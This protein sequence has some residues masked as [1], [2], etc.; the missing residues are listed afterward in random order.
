MN[1]AE[2]QA[3]ENP[4]DLLS[5]LEGRTSARKFR[6]FAAAV[7]R[8]AGEAG[9]ATFV[10]RYA[11]GQGGDQEMATLRALAEQRWRQRRGVGGRHRPQRM[12]Q[13]GRA[14]R[15]AWEALQPG[16][17]DAALGAARESILELREQQCE[18]LREVIGNPLA[19]VV[20]RTEWLAWEGGIVRR[21]ALEIYEERA[22]DRL[23]VLADALEDAGCA[24]DGL[25]RHCREMRA[26]RLGCWALDKLLGKQ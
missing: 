6:L 25:L 14:A 13:G 1:E 8:R 21:M 11:D 16:A 20:V 24:H 2:W 7:C 5:Y 19:V 26:H 3:C 15:V 18:D 22:F 9:T 10:E 4:Y 12:S 23:P 17:L